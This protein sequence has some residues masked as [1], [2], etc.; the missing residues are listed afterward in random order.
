MPKDFHLPQKLDLST[1]DASMRRDRAISRQDE[2]RLFPSYSTRPSPNGVPIVPGET[3]KK[4]PGQ[5]SKKRDPFQN[6][7]GVLKPVDKL[8]SKARES[9]PVR[10]QGMQGNRGGYQT[11]SGVNI[12]RPQTLLEQDL[13]ERPVK[14][15]RR[16]VQSSPTESIIDL[17]DD[18]KTG[19]SVTESSS[20]IGNTAR[21]SPGS[22][23]QSLKG[24]K[25]KR[26]NRNA[27]D[28]FRQVEKNMKA[29]RS[30]VSPRLGAKRFR[31]RFSPEDELE[32]CFTENAARERRFSIPS[33]KH[34]VLQS[35]EIQ[36]PQRLDRPGSPSLHGHPTNERRDSESRES[37]D[38]LQGAATVQPAQ[39]FSLEF[40][41][42]DVRGGFNAGKQVAQRKA[43]PADIRP[44]VFVPSSHQGKFKRK[45]TKSGT[46]PSADRC[47]QATSVRFGTTTGPSS[48]DKTVEVHVDPINETIKMTGPDPANSFQIPYNKVFK[49][50]RGTSPSCKVRLA[51][52]EGTG[53]QSVDID[54]TSSE[55]K[56]DLSTL[57]AASGAKVVEKDGKWMD[58]AF[59]KNE[60][61][62]TSGRYLNG[63][64]RSCTARA[65]EQGSETT[66]EVPKRPKLSASLQ[67]DLKSN[68][69]SQSGPRDSS[70]SSGLAQKF[71]ETASDEAM[72][73]TSVK[74]GT[75]EAVE[76]PV[77][78]YTGETTA[79]SRATRST[80]RRMLPAT[81]VSDD[82][83]ENSPQQQCQKISQKWQRPLVYPR[84]G[85]KKAEVDGQDLERLRDNEFLNDNLIGFYIRFLEDHLER[86]NKEVSKRVYFFNSYFFATLTNPPRGK[87]GINYEGVQKWTR[88][89]DIFSYDYIVVPI[90]EAAH[91]YVAIICNL[92]KLPGI[93]QE[94]VVVDEPAERDTEP[95]APPKRDDSENPNTPE[96][97][98]NIPSDSGET[99]SGAR[100]A[101]NPEKEELA[102]ESLAAMS[103]L[104]QKEMKERGELE[105]PASD[106]E[107]PEKEENPVSSPAKLSSPP[108][109]TEPSKQI[110]SQD[111]SQFSVSGSQ[112]SRKP[113]KKRH[114]PRYEVWQPTVITF[115]SLNLSRSPTISVLRNYLREEAQSKRGVDIDTTLVKGMKAQEIP[116]QPNY[117]DCGLYLLAYVEKFVQD[118][119]TFVTKLLRR[120]MRVEDDWPLLRSGLLRSRLRK[121][122]DE[123]YD[124]QEQL[125]REKAAERATMAD[126]QPISYLL[127][128]SEDKTVLAV[129]N[130]EDASEKSPNGNP[131]PE[132][133]GLEPAQK[134]KLGESRSVTRSSSRDGTPDSKAKTKR[135]T[136]QTLAASTL[137]ST[138]RKEVVEVPDSQ[139]Q[140]Q[141][142]D[143]T[144]HCLLHVEDSQGGQ[145]RS[146]PQGAKPV[147]DDAEQIQIPHQSADDSIVEVQVL[148]TPPPGLS[149]EKQDGVRKSPRSLKKRA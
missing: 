77:K 92:P 19:H 39:D 128:H 99:E 96:A 90:N 9:G 111:A 58:D 145:A 137:G 8:S 121:F 113:K 116:L 48:G 70:S 50:F 62:K 107:W 31:H 4:T 45:I 84:F 105:V 7:K 120:D 10:A 148:G 80:T 81:V 14:R 103:L 71:R 21:L 51:L 65:P 29:T 46:R 108:R 24:H 143:V 12:P 98:G 79:S 60:N 30:Q 64:K 112:K 97:V 59:K 117:S 69:V 114:G 126:R 146:R 53:D 82:E 41:K 67:N 11:L 123:L 75:E 142:E 47:F 42:K 131:P 27:V 54:L 15:R 73:A 52:R 23:Q 25:S 49:I 1:Q 36:K 130:M 68:V 38:E 5:T 132:K 149:T 102:R 141:Q 91:W 6:V 57:L 22:S 63:I 129:E 95:S 78:K 13:S 88:N 135:S 101:P 61:T 26:S 43:S 44:T 32:Q 133:S 110:N 93:A 119:D 106:E 139:E 28:E 127:G 136:P 3:F 66:V 125:S 72:K 56:E 85:K 83:E 104:D 122:L 144:S 140:V 33:V 2:Q 89:V 17:S 34:E 37:P 124:E 76:I 35:V 74:A 86:N 94:E 115:D 147:E 55:A 109:N 100:S 138:T 16:D 18:N 134:A 118:P 40:R 87:Q 20:V